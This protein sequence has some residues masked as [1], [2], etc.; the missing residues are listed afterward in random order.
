MVVN[1]FQWRRSTKARQPNE[2]PSF[3]LTLPRHRGEDRHELY[4][5]GWSLADPQTRPGETKN[6][7][8]PIIILASPATSCGVIIESS[9]NENGRPSF[10]YLRTKMVGRPLYKT[11][12]FPPN[13]Y[14]VISSIKH[15]PL[16]KQEFFL[17]QKYLEE[18]LSVR[19][20]AA[21]TFS[22]RQTVM[23]YL[24]KY[25]IPLRATDTRLGPPRYGERK[26]NG[27]IQA[28]KGQAQVIQKIQSMRAKNMSYE[29]IANALNSM[30]IP[31]MKKDAK[32]HGMS[33][34]RIVQS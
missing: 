17:R 33:V 19:K 30:N 20:I 8:D 7:L 26:V 2:T 14:V 5:W 23:A 15:I 16:V 18:R 9:S 12:F 13:N 29:N 3:H 31:T 21:L 11:T 6:H 34:R 28:H 10:L 32:W 25:D 24:K 1:L 27:K 22:A 4:L